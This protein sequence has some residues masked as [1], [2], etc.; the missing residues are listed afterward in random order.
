VEETATIGRDPASGDFLTV[1]VGSTQVGVQHQR[2]V[3]RLAWVYRSRDA[4]FNVTVMSGRSPLASVQMLVSDRGA[5]H[6]G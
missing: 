6:L 2:G 4:E 3:T 1:T 5:L